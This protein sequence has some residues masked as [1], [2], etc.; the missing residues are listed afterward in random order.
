MINFMN[1]MM[2]RH[3]AES[4][5]ISGQ[6]ANELGMLASIVPGAPMMGLMIGIM[7]VQNEPPPPSKLGTNDPTVGRTPL[8]SGPP[9]TAK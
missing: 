6:R 8:P 2:V 5:R 3:F 7:A 1:F 4:R 9:H